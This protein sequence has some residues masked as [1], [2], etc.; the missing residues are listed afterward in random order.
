MPDP[1]YNVNDIENLQYWQ[2]KANEAFMALKSNANVLCALLRFYRTVKDEPHFP[3]SLRHHCKQDLKNFSSQV[4]DLADDFKS[5]A[6]RAQFLISLISDR[7][8]H[9]SLHHQLLATDRTQSLNLSLAREA[10]MMRIITIVTLV[11]L[12]G[13]FVSVS[14]WASNCFDMKN[15]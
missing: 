3:A 9:L 10:I 11:F 15:I 4:R 14:R 1:E 5:E 12:P 8:E 7:R 2:D 6:S 13:T